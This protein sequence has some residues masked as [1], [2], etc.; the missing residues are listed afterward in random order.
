MVV[1][2]N[3]YFRVFKNIQICSYALFKNKKGNIKLCTCSQHVSQ[4]WLLNFLHK[5]WFTY[6]F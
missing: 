3:V 5:I 2:L 4:Y 1:S 6:V